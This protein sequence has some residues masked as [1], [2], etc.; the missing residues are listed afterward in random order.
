MVYDVS[1]NVVSSSGFSPA[2]AEAMYELAKNVA[3]VSD[4][5]PECCQAFYNELYPNR[6]LS[7]ISAVANLGCHTVL[8][9]DAAESLRPYLSVT[10]TYGDNYTEAIKN[11]TLS[12]T[13]AA[14]SNTITVTYMDETATVTVAAVNALPSGYARLEYIYTDGRQYIDPSLNTT[15][16]DYAEY[17]VMVRSQWYIKGGNILSSNNFKYPYLSGDNTNGFLSRIGFYYA[18]N[19][20]SSVT[21][22]SYLF[23]WKFDERHTIAGFGSGGAVTVDGVQKFAATKGSASSEPLYI[24]AGGANRI[25]GNTPNTSYSFMGRLYGMKLYKNNTLIRNYIPCKDSNNEAGLY[26][27][28]GGQFYKSASDKKLMRGGEV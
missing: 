11:F 1:G 14:G 21:S 17:E 25:D 24:F 19:G 28:V 4:K 6:E 15:D 13:I 10:A 27:I 9:G 16:V 7:S 8:A 5:G 12:G 23:P 2:I 3:Y 20:D 18:G 26:D 22:G